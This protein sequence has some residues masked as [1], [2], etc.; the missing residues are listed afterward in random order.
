MTR[1]QRLTFERCWQERVQRAGAITPGEKLALVTVLER[2]LTEQGRVP[3]ASGPVRVPVDHPMVEAVMEGRSVSVGGQTLGAPLAFGER[4]QALPVP[5]KLALL[6]LVGLL[7]VLFALMLRAGRG[8]EAMVA[9]VL[10]T[11]TP[12]VTLE[13]T[14]EPTEEATA[15]P[16]EVLP[17]ATPYSIALISGAAPASSNDPA[18][19]EIA[20]YSY[21]LATGT[22][23]NGIWEPAGAEWLDG[24]T[25]RRVIAIPYE[26]E[27]ANSLSALRSGTVL[28]LRL[29]SGEIVKYRV[30]EIERQQRQQ[31]EVLAAREP[32]LVVLLAGEPGPERWAIIATALQQPQD[33]GDYTTSP[34]ES[35]PPLPPLAAG[36]TTEVEDDDSPVGLSTPVT[37]E[38]STVITTSR[39]ITH[40]AAGLMLSVEECERVARI[41]E[42]EPPDNDQV[43]ML[44]EVTLLALEDNAEAVL[45]SGEHLAITEQRWMAEL[46]DW[47][48]PSVSASRSLRSGTL[49]P[50]STTRGRVAGLI[51]ADDGS[52]LSRTSSEPILIWEQ[53]G[54]QYRILLGADPDPTPNP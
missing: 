31:I 50:G 38:S 25:L 44:C 41:A 5:A 54:T 51:N 24:T 10:E 27:V 53:A 6:A 49:S 7:P 9:G 34:D 33:F 18:S 37:L 20:G 43:F 16:T 15:Q 52:L 8:D 45:F 2:E 4:M 47:W 28:Q 35:A 40:T 26:R 29:R 22:V 46:A 1:S 30:T 42:Q 3:L 23:Q 19:L 11:P 48:P 36:P 13:P 12:T 32:S 21:I 39:T 14:R 17:T